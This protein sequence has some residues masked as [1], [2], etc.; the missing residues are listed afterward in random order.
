MVARLDRAETA[1]TSCE[2]SVAGGGCPCPCP[3]FKRFFS[4]HNSLTLFLQPIPIIRKTETVDR[5]GVAVPRTHKGPPNLGSRFLHAYL[6]DPLH[7]THVKP[8]SL[9]KPSNRFAPDLAR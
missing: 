7:D 3:A 4:F 6:A 2:A 5:D 1:C 8:P 9:P